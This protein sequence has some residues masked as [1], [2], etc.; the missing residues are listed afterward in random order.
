MVPSQGCQ[1][2]MIDHHHYHGDKFQRICI[3]ISHC[4]EMPEHREDD[5][6]KDY[7]TRCCP[8]GSCSDRCEESVAEICFVQLGKTSRPRGEKP[9]LSNMSV[10]VR[11]FACASLFGSLV[12][13]LCLGSCSE[14]P[15]A[16]TTAT[17]ASPTTAPFFAQ[18]PEAEPP[19]PA[20]R[21][22]APPKAAA[23]AL[24]AE[25][26]LPEAPPKAAAAATAAAATTTNSSTDSN[27][28]NHSDH[29]NNMKPRANSPQTTI[30]LPCPSHHKWGHWN[31]RSSHPSTQPNPSNQINRLC[32]SPRYVI[33]PPTPPPATI[34]EAIWTCDVQVIQ[35]TRRKWTPRR[36]SR[37]RP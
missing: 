37:H 31:L 27:N 7:V 15:V 16:A 19:L 28:S 20:A 5:D 22:E 18:A 8:K 4:K 32:A 26:P 17:A 30:H 10:F 14:A 1:D 36:S 33:I 34:S 29:S 2:F 25:T 35:K 21:P 9:R 11:G 23:E 12:P 3:S 24:E 6:R 13:L